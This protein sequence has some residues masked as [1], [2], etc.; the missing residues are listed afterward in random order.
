MIEQITN[1]Y[2]TELQ[3]TQ[4]AVN[5]SVGT[6]EK[7]VQEQGNNLQEFKKE[8][9]TYFHFLDDGLEI[10]K[11]EDGGLMPFSSLLSDQRLEFRQDGNPVA[12]I[13]YNKLHIKNVEAVRTFSVGAAEDGG[14]F[15]FI[16]TKYGM[17]VK[18]RAAEETTTATA[19]LAKA[20]RVR[21][22]T[23]YQ[24]VIDES[25]VFE[26]EAKT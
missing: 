4:N 14:Y 24:Q 15:D 17:G 10:G 22:R 23:Q 2:R 3:Q 9:E 25:G 21:R 16:S 1:Q 5:I 8:Y 26:M 12:Y 13:Q 20:A 19:S 7:D 11:K 18:W 6:V